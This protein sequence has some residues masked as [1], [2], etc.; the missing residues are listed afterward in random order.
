MLAMLTVLTRDAKML[1][2]V[3]HVHP[4]S[5]TNPKLIEIGFASVVLDK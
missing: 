2:N 3:C 4:L 1:N 5:W